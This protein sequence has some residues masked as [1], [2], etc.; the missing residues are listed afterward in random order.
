MTGAAMRKLVLP[1]LLSLFISSVAWSQ[2]PPLKIPLT[3]RKALQMALLNNVDLRVESLSYSMTK[4][5]VNRSRGIYDPFLTMGIFGRSTYY[6]VP[7]SRTRYEDVSGN[8]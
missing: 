2:D 4:E 7:G 3:M 5:D 6:A 1:T 8:F